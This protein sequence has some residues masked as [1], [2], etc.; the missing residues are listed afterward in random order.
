MDFLRSL[1]TSLFAFTE[2]NLQWDGTLLHE[3]TSLQRRFF[4]HG[5]LVTSESDLQFPTSYKPG[6]TCIGVNGKWTTRVTDRGVD[7]S[8]QGR[9]SYV[10]MSGRDA[11][12][13]MFISAYRVCQKA[14]SKAGP[15]TSYAQQW[16]MSHVA[17]NPTPDP[18]NDFITDLVQFVKDQRKLKPLAINI[19]LDANES[20]GDEAAGLQRLTT[21]L[22]LTDVHGNQLNAETAPTTYI[23]GTKRIDYGLMC[24]LLLKYVIR[25]GFGAFHD[26]PVTDHRWAH[27]DLDLAGYFN[28]GVTAI[29]HLAGRS[30]K[31]KSPKEVAKYRELLHRHLCSHNI[32]KRLERL[33]PLLPDDWN[34]CNE[35]E[36][37]EIDDRISEGM[38]NAE[39]KACRNRNLPWSSSLKA[40]Q[41]GVECW[42]KIISSIKNKL[43]CRTQVERLIKKLPPQSRACYMLDQ[44]HTLPEATANLRAARRQRY[45]VMSQAT[46]YRSI[47]LH[48]LAA[49]AAL[50]GDDDKE[51]ILKRLVSAQERSET[52]QRLH[53]VFKPANTGAIS[54]LEVPTGEWQWPYDP[55]QVTTWTRE[56]DSQ[57][58]EDHLFDRNILHFGQAKETPWTKPPFSDIPFDGTGPIADAILDGTF[59]YEP[60]EPHGKYIQLLLDSLQAKLPTLPSDITAKDI[61]NGFRVWKEMTSTSPS[62]RHLGHYKALLSLDGREDNDSTTHLAEDIM[63]IHHRMTAI[64][65]KLGISLHRWQEVVTA[66]LEKDNGSPK[67]HRLR[68]IH[69]LEADLN[70]LIKI[71]I[72]RRFVWHGETHGTFGEAQAG[73]RPGRSANDIVLQKELTYDLALRTL[74]CLAMMENDATAC[75]DRMLPSLVTLSLRANGVSEAIAK[76]IGA[77]LLK[78]RYRI[79]TKLGISKRFY[80]HS[81]D[82]P[83][84]G[85]GHV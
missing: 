10:T 26:G 34:A 52:Y 70:L 49:A 84:Y 25:C 43:N 79:K 64:C 42:L 67:L 4:S 11:P 38:I 37:N 6:G 30:L 72:A 68:V 1:H 33:E 81:A 44:E 65:A 47:F 80:S 2:P 69:L 32:F 21:E 76:I 24:P 85:T 55:K 29:E 51:T 57:K 59:P 40:A 39:N 28:G 75:F 77:T 16:T 19:N 18:R 7:P 62:N 60:S 63:D 53:H 31:S 83:V 15:L 41:I 36:L 23:R 58:V 66:M 22:G 48:E 61:S 12:D 17:G 3:A 54:H 82:H 35:A 50:A 56:Y 27:I 13:I 45:T 20:M 8:G 78:M 71:I 5:L 46:D 73:G 14:G 9:W 74:I